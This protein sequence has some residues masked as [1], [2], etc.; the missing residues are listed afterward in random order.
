MLAPRHTSTNAGV[1]LAAYGGPAAE[2]RR[3]HSRTAETTAAIAARN[4]II[5][6][7]AEEFYAGVSMH[8]AAYAIATALRRYHCTAW[9]R[10][11]VLSCC[12]SRHAGR[13]AALLW[14]VL[15]LRPYPL[16]ARAIRYVLAKNNLARDY[17]LPRP[18]PKLSHQ[19]QRSERDELHRP[20]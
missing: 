3:R 6:R 19:P 7:L 16:S 18:A 9:Q 13:Q 11:R 10:E 15:K 5:V 14:L 17:S 20:S 12:P 4:A 2:N 1:G 8:A